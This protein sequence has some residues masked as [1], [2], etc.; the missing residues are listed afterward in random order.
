MW[1]KI[2]CQAGEKGDFRR[3]WTGFAVFG[4]Q[5]A[6]TVRRGRTGQPSAVERQR[7]MRQE[8]EDDRQD[9]DGQGAICMPSAQSG[10]HAWKHGRR[11]NLQRASF[12]NQEGAEDVEHR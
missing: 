10:A 2:S 3:L 8:R 11:V 12:S 5:R 4:D 6:L 7:F 9:K 1:L